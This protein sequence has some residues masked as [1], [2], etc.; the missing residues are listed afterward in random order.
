MTALAGRWNFDGRPDDGACARM[1]RALAIYGPHASDW[2]AEEGV[3]MGRALFRTLPED[4]YDSQPMAGGGGRWLM[5]ADVRIDNREELVAA[6]GTSAAAARTMADGALLLAAWE[7]WEEGA[8]DR[9]VGDFAFALW[10]REKRRLVLARDA[11]G[12][13]PLY[14]HRG[15]NFIA[16]ATMAKGLHVLPEIP[17]APD[18]ERVLEELALLFVVGS[19]CFFVGFF[20]VVS[21]YIVVLSA[22]GTRTARHWEPKRETLRLGST[23]AYADA[24]RSHL[25]VAVKA[26]LR[27][28]GTRVGAQLSSGFDSAAV[29]TSAALQMMPD[30]NVVAFTAVPRHGYDGPDPR[31]RTGNEGP[32]A[33]LTAA[34]YGNIEHVL[35]ANDRRSPVE[36]LDRH[37]FLFER[38]VLNLCNRVWLDAINQAA[39]D[40]GL[41]VMLTGQMGNM[42]I[43][44][45]GM[46]LL[47]QLVRRGRWLRW[48][49]VGCVL[50]LWVGLCFCGVLAASL[51]G[52]VPGS[53]WAWL[54]ARA[55]REK[56]QLS[57]YSALRAGYIDV[58]ALERR[59]AERALDFHYR[60]R[61][62]GFD[63]RL[64]ALRRLDLG[65]TGKGNLVGWQIDVRDPTADRRLIEFSL[66]IPDEQW[67]R[68]GER[69]ALSRRAFAGRIP[70]AVLS[71]PK[72]GIQAVDW[73]EGLTDARPA[74]AEEIARLRACASSTNLLDLDRLQRMVADWPTGGWERDAVSLPYRF[75]LLRGISSG[76][77]LRKASGSNG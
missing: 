33:A 45:D 64:W 15:R 17:V 56:L 9:L 3:A 38:P 55:G 71:E 20:C 1:L 12:A 60:P 19:C 67:L 59:A 6:L 31:N 61:K 29:T 49:R 22:E 40:R 69:R 65:N 47:P 77:F 30:G 10:D 7:R 75:A 4:R 37:F 14:Y 2:C 23:E 44:Y 76:H 50:V 28:A 43:S 41:A 27:G 35:V 32:G 73:H 21:G 42:T 16:F 46:T 53:L 26:R 36:R 58:A 8:L 11:L 74:V 18:E 63:T 48:W 52:Y 25:D 51:G 72:G 68:A 57:E 39:R 5:V 54:N 24:L 70:A 62:D 13:R 34:A 66:S